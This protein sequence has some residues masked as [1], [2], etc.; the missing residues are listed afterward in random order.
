[1]IVV[2]TM[3]LLMNQRSTPIAAREAR[4]ASSP[5]GTIPKNSL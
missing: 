3:A 2:A 4:P 5:S 1:V